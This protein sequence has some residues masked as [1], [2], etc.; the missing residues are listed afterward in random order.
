MERPHL[1]KI[2][3]RLDIQTKYYMGQEWWKRRMWDD[4][5]QWLSGHVSGTRQDVKPE[6]YNYVCLS[7]EAP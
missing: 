1:E 3:Q 4:K 5:R 7:F 6:E 2:R